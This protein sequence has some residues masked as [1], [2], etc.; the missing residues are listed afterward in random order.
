MYNALCVHTQQVW[1]ALD[2]FELLAGDV[3][4]DRHTSALAA[5]AALSA[6]LQAAVGLWSSSTAQQ[7]LQL[8]E[9][10]VARHCERVTFLTICIAAMAGPAEQTDDYVQVLNCYADTLCI[11]KYYEVRCCYC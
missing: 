11:V 9:L 8:V 6:A 2:E 5:V 3:A 7:T 10:E 1:T 4:Q